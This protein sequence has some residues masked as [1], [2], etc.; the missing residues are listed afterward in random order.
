MKKEDFERELSIAKAEDFNKEI[1]TKW[2]EAGNAD[3]IKTCGNIDIRSIIAMEELAECS[4]A[5][6]KS[7]RKEDFRINLIEEIGDVFNMLYHVMD[8]HGITEEDIKKAMMVKI[9]R[10]FSRWS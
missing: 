9:K 8:R 6:S 10:D 3:A 2:N 5:I 4:Q 1:W 7:L